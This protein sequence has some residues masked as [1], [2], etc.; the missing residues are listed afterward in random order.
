MADLDLLVDYVGYLH[1]GLDQ[2]DRLT[3]E[4]ELGK[5]VWTYLSVLEVDPDN[6]VARQQVGQ[7]ATAVRQ[8]DR[9]APGRRWLGQI[10][11]NSTSLEGFPVWRRIA[12]IGY[13]IVLLVAIFAMGFVLG[14]YSANQNSKTLTPPENPKHPDS[15][16]GR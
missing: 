14:Q 1:S 3:R 12:G 16:M 5:A 9:S 10:R 13:V 7:I 2:A 6:P 4:G 11:G 8:F 15:L